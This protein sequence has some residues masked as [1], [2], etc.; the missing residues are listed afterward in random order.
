MPAMAPKPATL[1]TAAMRRAL[2]PA[3]GGLSYSSSTAA[4][5]GMDLSLTGPFG[6]FQLLGFRAV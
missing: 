4:P 1:T 2:L 3:A 6:D 5:A